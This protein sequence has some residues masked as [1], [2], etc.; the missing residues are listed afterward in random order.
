MGKGKNSGVSSS[1]KIAEVD[2]DQVLEV[3]KNK[4]FLA[5]RATASSWP[6]PSTTEEQ[7]KELADE[8]LIYD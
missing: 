7:L 4:E 8:G 1:K 6:V 2:K 3:I 5:M